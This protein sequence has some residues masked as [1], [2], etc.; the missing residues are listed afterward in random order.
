MS[1]ELTIGTVEKIFGLA[2]LEGMLELGAL[3]EP[4]AIFGL[5]LKVS[6]EQS[7]CRFAEDFV[8]Q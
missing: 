1:V 8:Q 5:R 6:E 7:V 4:E 2:V 3:E